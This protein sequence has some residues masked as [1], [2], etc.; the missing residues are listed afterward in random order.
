MSMQIVKWG[1][2]ITAIALIGFVVYYFILKNKT[3]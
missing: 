2:S 3:K 1:I